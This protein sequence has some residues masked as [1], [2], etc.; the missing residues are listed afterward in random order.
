[1]I[2]ATMFRSVG[3]V[4]FGRIEEGMPAFL[5]IILTPLTFH[6]AG[7]P[8]GLHLPRRPLRPAGVH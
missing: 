7:D 3:D 2:G 5:T 8:V 1:M 6:H 4:D